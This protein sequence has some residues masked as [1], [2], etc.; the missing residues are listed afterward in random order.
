[1]CEQ[2][3]SLLL[4]KT[5]LQ[6]VCS[7]SSF[8]F[9]TIQLFVW[10]PGKSFE[11]IYYFP[12]HASAIRRNILITIIKFCQLP[13][14]SPFQQ[15]S[16]W[17]YGLRCNSVLLKL[18]WILLLFNLNYIRNLASRHK[19]FFIPVDEYA[20]FLHQASMLK[21]NLLGLIWNIFKYHFKTDT[22]NLSSFLKPHVFTSSEF[23]SNNYRNVLEK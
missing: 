2:I 21:F 17:F 11:D 23:D 19:L 9:P 18:E 7:Y 5:H 4:I 10:T 12:Q 15:H 3:K 6:K 16:W 1:M 22:G 20:S 14:S 8:H 13:S